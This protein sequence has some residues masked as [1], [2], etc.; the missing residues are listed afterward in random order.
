MASKFAWPINNTYIKLQTFFKAI[1]K[2]ISDF[3]IALH[4]ASGIM[5]TY[6]G[7]L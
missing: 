6:L 2:S 4:G 5:S 1:N 3:Q 7:V